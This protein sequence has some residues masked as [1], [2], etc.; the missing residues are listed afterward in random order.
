MKTH[1]NAD[2]NCVVATPFAL[3]YGNASQ[4]WA[5]GLTA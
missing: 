1:S 2:L 4:A 5:F 3:E